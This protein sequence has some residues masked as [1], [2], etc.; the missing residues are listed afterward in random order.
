MLSK[1]V[2]RPVDTNQSPSLYHARFQVCVYKVHQ[3]NVVAMK[4]F[5]LKKRKMPYKQRIFKEGRQKLFFENQ[6]IPIDDMMSIPVPDFPGLEKR[7][8]HGIAS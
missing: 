2:H 7:T 5:Y 4:T 1:R 3:T 6:S 8:S